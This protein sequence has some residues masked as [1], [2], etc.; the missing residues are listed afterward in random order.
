MEQYGEAWGVY[1]GGDKHIY[2]KASGHWQV[3]RILS[4]YTFN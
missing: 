4:K 3:L 2:T 1:G